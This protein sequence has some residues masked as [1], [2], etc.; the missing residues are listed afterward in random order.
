VSLALYKGKNIIFEATKLAEQAP[1]TKT[2]NASQLNTLRNIKQRVTSIESAK[3]ILLQGSIDIEQAGLSGIIETNVYNVKEFTQTLEFGSYGFTKTILKNGAGKIDNF[4][5]EQVLNGLYLE[6]AER[7]HPLADMFWSSLYESITAIESKTDNQK[8]VYNV[9]LEKKG[10]PSIEAV[11][12]AS[13]GDLI[14]RSGYTLVK[15]L[16]QLPYKITYGNYTE[17]NGV[18]LPMLI[19]LFNPASGNVTINYKTFTTN[20]NFDD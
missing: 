12:D 16:G 13:T 20:Q 14:S 2:L 19:K 11:I 7:D 4:G 1:G 15:D 5:D 18:R 9:T 17:V 6:Q 8:V 3:G 10:L